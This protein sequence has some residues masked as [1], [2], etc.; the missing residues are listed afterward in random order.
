MCRQSDIFLQLMMIASLPFF[1][2]PGTF[3]YCDRHRRDAA[4]LYEHIQPS[5][6]I[7]PHTHRKKSV[8]VGKQRNQ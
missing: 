1:F 7:T 5:N 8:E 2:S 6:P 4:T 3:T